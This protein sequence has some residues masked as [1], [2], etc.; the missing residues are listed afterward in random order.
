MA[1]IAGLRIREI[2]DNKC[3]VSVPFKY[4]TK[5]PFRSIYFAVQSM[6][7]EMSTATA[8]LLAVEGQKTSIAWII[9]NM[10]AHFPKKATD[11]VYYTCEEVKAAFNAVEKVAKS[12]KDTP[13]SITLKTTGKMKD[14]TV[15]GNFEFTWSFKRRST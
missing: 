5:N 15:V 7:A 14:G 10:K 2:N 11:R 4:L 8:C 3:T 6:A 1:F 9:I 12:D 13:E